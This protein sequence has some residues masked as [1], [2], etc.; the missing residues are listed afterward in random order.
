MK[1]PYIPN[2]LLNIIF[3]Y[4]GRIKYEKGKFINIIHKHDNRYNILKPIIS[5]KLKILKKIYIR[6]DGSFCFEFGFDICN[7]VGLCYDYGYDFNDRAIF[8]ICYFDVRDEWI[9]IR[10]LL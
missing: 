10:T 7:S 4:D 2:E 9:Q 8:E 5:K 6:E 1:T 3:E